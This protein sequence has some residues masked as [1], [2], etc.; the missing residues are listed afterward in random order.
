MRWTPRIP[1]R[2]ASLSGEF[3]LAAR[4]FRQSSRTPRRRSR[5]GRKGHRG[6][7]RDCRFADA[8]AAGL[9]RENSPV[10]EREGYTG[11]EVTSDLSPPVTMHIT[12]GNQKRRTSREFIAQQPSPVSAIECHALRDGSTS[13]RG[14]SVHPMISLFA[15]MSYSSPYSGCCALIHC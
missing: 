9:P 2:A 5:H 7:D 3:G 11:S 8:L 12:I 6:C 4:D 1:A 15:V 13:N 10:R 14:A